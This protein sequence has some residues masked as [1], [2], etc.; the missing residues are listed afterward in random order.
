MKVEM[1]DGVFEMGVVPEGSEDERSE[2][3]LPGGPTPISPA[4]EKA[5]PV[6]MGPEV[7]VKA[8]RRRFS[9]GYKLRILKEADGCSEGEVGA[10]LRRKGL[11]WSNLLTW[12]R[13]RKEG[14][15]KGL[16]PKKRGPKKATAN[17]L[18][19]EMKK[20]E[21]ENRQLRRKLKRAEIM[22]DIQKKASE[23]LGIPLEILDEEE[24]H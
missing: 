11:Y 12:R 3:A 22:L 4:A 13:Q 23:L 5:G 17:P 7:T 20:L 24:D 19:A 14:T 10:L 8:T 15:L 1:Q 16:N 9:A 6:L 2:P 18:T 21:R